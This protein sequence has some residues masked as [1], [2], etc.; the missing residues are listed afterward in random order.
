M[1]YWTVNRAKK[2]LIFDRNHIRPTKLK[3][4]LVLLGHF[5]QR[6]IVIWVSFHKNDS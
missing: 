1:Q 6:L 5:P 4:F 2:L 3:L